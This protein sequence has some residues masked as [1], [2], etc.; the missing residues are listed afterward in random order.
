[1]KYTADD[2]RELAE[3]FALVNDKYHRIASAMLRQA[4]D[5]LDSLPSVVE[6]RLGRAER[7]QK[8]NIA[9]ELFD[10]LSWTHASGGAEPKVCWA[11]FDKLGKLWRRIR[12]DADNIESEW[13]GGA[14]G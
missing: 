5:T 3:E 9:N 12:Y 4:A 6:S 13:H 14:N 10:C 8:D 2:M 11:D 7:R 1:M